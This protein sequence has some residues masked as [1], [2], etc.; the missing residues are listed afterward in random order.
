MVNQDPQEIFLIHHGN[1]DYLKIAA[2]CSQAAGNQ[3]I[4]IGNDTETAQFCSAY[5]DDGLIDLPEYQEFERQY[6]HLSSA[7]REFEL[8]CFK[9]YF[10][11]Y[12]IAKQREL[13]H[14][15]MIDS[16]A[17]VLQDLS[18]IAND[19]LIPNHYC[20]GISTPRQSSFHE[21]GF[22]WACSP[23]T[24]F[25]T[26]EGLQDFLNFLSNLYTGEVRKLLDQKYEWH[27]QN[28]MPGG[29][30]DMTALFLWQRSKTNV[31]NLAK[32]HLDG[33]PFFDNNLNE[34]GNVIDH[35]FLMVSNVILKKVIN[36]DNRYWV[37]KQADGQSIPAAALHFQGRAKACMATFEKAQQLTY[38]TYAP[39]AFLQY[40]TKRKNS[41]VRKIKKV[42]P[43]F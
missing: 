9:R 21:A 37:S 16:D 31:Y 7:S 18:T 25:W 29:I 19:F 3:V 11:L 15:W 23:H 34:D 36:K 24:S 12:A 32:A 28:N 40:V 14:F 27:L 38:W 13:H 26:L 33:L 1:Q 6:V 43:I 5:Y 42:I 39:H 4:L 2:R 20:A 8:L 17:I 30:C 41:L 35:E 22:W 10:Y